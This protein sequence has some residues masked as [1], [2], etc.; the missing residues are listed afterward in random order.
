MAGISAAVVA[1]TAVW[2]VLLLLLPDGLGRQLLG[3]TWA[4]V[5][6]ILVP[7]VVA[8][9]VSVASLGP[10]CGVYAAKRPRVLFPLQLM[11]APAFLIGGV[12][13]VL[14]GGAVG[15]AVGIALAHA[16]NAGAAWIRF[17]V[18]AR[19]VAADDRTTGEHDRPPAS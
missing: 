3:D 15:A 10:T 17:T 7:T 12:A 5:D 16:F 2:G 13:G 1:P 9:V 11:A 8:M 14:V 19:L 4:G 6:S 18:V